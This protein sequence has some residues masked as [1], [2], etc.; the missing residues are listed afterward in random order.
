MQPARQNPE[1]TP[2]GQDTCE[3]IVR[4]EEVLVRCALDEVVRQGAQELLQKAVEVEVELFTERYQYLMDDRGR[5]QV[6]RNGH[7]PARSILTGAGALQVVAP[8]V[9]DRIL[10]QYGDRRFSSALLPP[11]L[12]K[13]KKLEELLPA[14]YLAGISTGDFR[15]AL[16]ALLGKDAVGLSAATIVRLKEVWQQDYTVFSQ[17]DLSAK[18]YV[19]WWVDGIYFHARMEPDRPCFLV[20][21]G[22]GSDGT[23]ELVAV[24][25]GFRESAE[26]WRVLLRDL[27][28]RGLDRGPALATGDGSL[29]FWIALAEV[30]PE[31]HPQLCWV[32]KTANVLDKLPNALQGKAKDMLH[33][34]SLAESRRQA[35]QAWERFVC[36]FSEKYPKAVACLSNHREKLL[37]FYTYPAEHWQHIRSTNVIESSFATVRLRTH[38]TKGCLSRSTALT[39]VFKLIESASKRWRRLR[40]FRHLPE[41]LA[42]VRYQDGIRVA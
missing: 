5:R 42:G 24:E 10:E 33:D 19:Y 34:I 38:R 25:T 18:Q 15:H 16:E 40:G 39:M 23:K 27:K 22:A 13:S 7:R 26:S 37:A 32:H 9:D 1:D 20:I 8:R 3:R 14:L 6:V 21:I 36:T 35:D 17:R 31:S 2:V 29:G 28:R 30:S 12:R 4:P 41:V 11:Y